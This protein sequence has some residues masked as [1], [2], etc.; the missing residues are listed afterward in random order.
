MHGT[1]QELMKR[2]NSLILKNR[3]TICREFLQLN[4]IHQSYSQQG[5]HTDQFL[6]SASQYLCLE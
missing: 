3:N 5:S 1:V 2:Q 6:F 4:I